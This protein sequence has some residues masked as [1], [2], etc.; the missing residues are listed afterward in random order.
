MS[1]PVRR[2]DYKISEKWCGSVATTLESINMPNSP[3]TQYSGYI[4]MVS[5]HER[6]YYELILPG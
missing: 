2:V 6:N 3:N 4:A 5:V 1:K